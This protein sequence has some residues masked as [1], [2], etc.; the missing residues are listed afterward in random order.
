VSFDVGGTLIEPWPSV[1]DIY[2][3]VAAEQGW[4]GLSVETLNR[5]FA[6][7]WKAHPNFQ[8]QRAQ[9]SALVDATFRGLI[10]TAPSRSFFSALYERF[11]DPGSWRIYEDVVPALEGL[12]AR[13]FRLAVISNWDERLRPLLGR[14]RLENRFEQI[15]VSCESGHCKPS[16]FIFKDAAARL[17]VPPAALVHIGDSR[18]HDV[19]GARGAGLQALQLVRA[20]EPRGRVASAPAGRDQIESLFALEDMLLT[21]ND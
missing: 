9:W 5:R 15:V 10:A 14:L 12:K 18:E 13:G 20:R 8:H 6:A 7:A 16:P 19:E 3:Q 11:E 17:D 1:G 4:P 2:A 21:S